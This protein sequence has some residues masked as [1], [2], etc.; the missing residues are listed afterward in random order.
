MQNIKL[1]CFPYAGGSSIVFSKWKQFLTKNAG[2]EL[3]ALELP[4]RGIRMLE[5]LYA[6]LPEAVEDLYQMIS[7]EISESPYALFGHSLGGLL[8]YELAQKI[9]QLNT[10]QPLHL[11][12]SGKSAPHVERKKKYHLMNNEEFKRELL[13]LGGTPPEFFDH[14][15]LMDLFLPLLKHDFKLAE[16]SLT[17]RKLDPLDCDITVFLGKEDHEISIE[18]ANGWKLHTQRSCTLHYFNGNHFFINDEAA[19]VTK[20]IDN[21]LSKKQQRSSNAQKNAMNF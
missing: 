16:T 11:F 4:G 9:K 12:F 8:V 13:Q 5:P 18:D 19:A 7:D 15:E 20:L 2:I 6:G 1:F 14:P 10:R 17:E 21:T 3:R